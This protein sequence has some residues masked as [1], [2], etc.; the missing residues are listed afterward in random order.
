MTTDCTIL[1]PT[2][3][4]DKARATGELAVERAGIECEA[5]D[6]EDWTH[7]GYTHTVNRGLAAITDGDVCVLV[8][9]CEPCDGWLA[10]LAEAVAERAA[11]KVWFAGPSGPCRTPPQNS[12]RLGDGRR[13]RTV[14]HLAGFCLY[15]TRECLDSLGGLDEAYTHYASDVDWQRR[16]RRDYGANS[17]WVPGAYVGHEL[18]APHL[19]WW[20]R[21]QRLLQERWG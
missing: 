20:E 3:D 16:A 17:L 15:V 11:L 9:D 2:L 21:D 8:D 7:A 12:G 1:I 19:E 10:Q 4:L 5:L 13:P 18:H 6:V 14:A